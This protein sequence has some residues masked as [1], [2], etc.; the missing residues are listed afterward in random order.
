MPWKRDEVHLHCV[1]VQ[2]PEGLAMVKVKLDTICNSSNLD[3][4][5]IYSYGN[6]SLGIINWNTCILYPEGPTADNQPVNLR[7]R[8][9]EKWQF[10]TA[11]KGEEP[12]DGLIKFNTASLTH[13]IDS[14]L[15]AGEN[16]RTIKL[17]TGDTPPAF[18]HIVSETKDA[19]KLSDRVIGIYS[20]LV[21][22]AVALFGVAHYTEFHFLVTCSN[23]LGM[24]C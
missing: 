7:L 2:I 3:A 14:P 10:A 5:A 22:E 24:L 8:L 4:G 6:K 11:L 21:R 16:L 1:S 23:E 17:D 20:R 19:L 12:K 9:P 13:V 15:V 18:M